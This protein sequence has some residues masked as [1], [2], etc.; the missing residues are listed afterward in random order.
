MGAKNGFLRNKGTDELIFWC[1]GTEIAAFDTSKMG[2]FEVAP[3]AQESHVADA[4]ATNTGDE[5]DHINAHLADLETFGLT[6][7]S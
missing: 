2:F 7:T 1:N 6:A 4:G 3:A 5:K